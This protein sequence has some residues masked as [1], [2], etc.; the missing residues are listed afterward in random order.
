MF[1]HWRGSLSVCRGFSSRDLTGIARR[2][3]SGKRSERIRNGLSPGMVNGT[4]V[5]PYIKRKLFVSYL[6][7][8]SIWSTNCSSLYRPSM[9]QRGLRNCSYVLSLT[10]LS[11]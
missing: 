6:G 2:F 8:D 7:A 11:Q 5:M 9:E 10:L 3:R 4:R 1:H